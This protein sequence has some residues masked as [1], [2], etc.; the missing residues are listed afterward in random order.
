MEHDYAGRIKTLT[1]K[2]K[3]TGTDAAIITDGIN[4]RYLSGFTGTEAYLIVSGQDKYI[5]TDSRYTGQ[6]RKESP[7]WETVEYRGI[8]E[9][10]I[11]GIVQGMNMQRIGFEDRNL[12][13]FRYHELKDRL[14]IQMVPLGGL[15]DELRMEKESSEIVMMRKAA[16]I[17]DDAFSYILNVIRPGITERETAAE[18]E[19]HMKKN[20]AEKESFSTIVA[21]GARSSLPH[22]VASEKTI[23]YGDTIVLDFGAVY[24]GYCSDMT[25]TIFTGHPDDEIKKVYEV[26]LSAQ[27]KALEKLYEGIKGSEA[28]AVARNFI[29]KSGYGE[30]FGHGLGHG[31]GLEVHEE[32]RLAANSSTVLKNGMAVTVEPG[33]YI[34]GKAGVRIEDLVVINGTEP[35][36]LTES[37]K[38]LIVL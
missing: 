3:D 29:L 23:E 32:P 17:A 27:Q 34:A 10:V 18:L 19:Y 9:P 7:G 11:A 37:T 5:V 38:E 30:Y 8:M 4:I 26:V 13:F 31:V 1:G 16:G 28:D 24:N 25:R 12:T 14:G 21:S 20:G 35:E 33:I 2:L 22:G 36:V 15:V 6:A